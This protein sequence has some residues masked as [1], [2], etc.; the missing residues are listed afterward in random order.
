MESNDFGP[1]TQEAHKLLEAPYQVGD[2]HAPESSVIGDTASTESEVI[3][4]TEDIT[5]ITP[6]MALPREH[7]TG[8][9]STPKHYG[10][11]ISSS[12]WKRN[13]SW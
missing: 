13:S 8:N 2:N 7:A 4:I 6:V 12:S 5:S 10:E 1:L 3:P 9:K 11:G